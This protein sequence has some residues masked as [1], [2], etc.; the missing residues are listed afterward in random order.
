MVVVFSY[1]S[2]SL[3]RIWVTLQIISSQYVNMSAILRNLVINYHL[4]VTWSSLSSKYLL[5]L[6]LLQHSWPEQAISVISHNQIPLLTLCY[7]TNWLGAVKAKIRKQWQCRSLS[8]PR[9]SS[10]NP[11]GWKQCHPYIFPNASWGVHLFTSFLSI[12][13]PVLPLFSVNIFRSIPV[14]A[15]CTAVSFT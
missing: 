13:R 7:H 15:P 11:V 4:I 2:S 12:G 3:P 14:L 5:I 9:D 10:T 1:D 8:L 6:L